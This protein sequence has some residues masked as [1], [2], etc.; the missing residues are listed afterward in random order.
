MMSAHSIALVAA[1][2]VLIVMLASPLATL[3]PEGL[4]DLPGSV[5]LAVCV[6]LAAWAFVS[7]RGGNFTVLPEPRGSAQLITRGPY[8]YVR[9]PMY[10]AVL[11]LGLGAA[12]TRNTLGD[13]ITCALL[14]LV[15]LLKIQR[16][17]GLLTERY[18]EYPAYRTRTAALVP[19]LY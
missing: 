16:E 14:V 15:M 7:M 18:A 10:T 19:G 17:E 2:M 4:A 5:C 6:A 11:L 9:H 8:A 1:Q 12:L 3:V 13:W